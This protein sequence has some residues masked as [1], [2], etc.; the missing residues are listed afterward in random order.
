[1]FKSV[2]P[3]P[4]FINL[5][6]RILDFWRENEILEK[7]LHRND[8]PKGKELGFSE[9]DSLQ[10]KE[11]D[12]K[13]SSEKRFSFLDGPITAN[14]PMGVHHAWGRTLKDLFQRFRN[15]QGFK[16][17]FQNG[18]DNQGLWVEV[19]VEKKLGFK[20]K[21][22][23]EKFGI[24][25]FVEECKKY[26]LG[27]AKLM[28]KQS[29][30]LGYFMDWGNDYY[31]MSDENN[32]AI[33]HFLK[34]VWEDGNLYK[35]R[36]SVP[37]C[38]RCGTAISQHE[39]L[40]EEYQ[41]L[42]H[43]SVF[44]KYPMV[45]GPDRVQPSLRV[46]P[47]RGVSLLVW[48]TTPW[49]IPG[50][51]ALAVNPE[52]KYVGICRKPQTANR[53]SECLI[54][55]KSRLEVIGEPYEIVREFL[56]TELEGLKYIGPFDDLECVKEAREE[57]PETFHTVVLSKDLVSEEEGTGI[58]HI[59]TGCGTEDF[60]LG[61]EKNLPVIEVI[62]EA[63][64]YLDGFGEFSG[65]NA[66]DHPELILDYLGSGTPLACLKGRAPQGGAATK[67]LINPFLYKIEPFTH[68]YPVCWRCKTELVWRV[69][70]EW[71]IAMDD[72][73][74]KGAKSYRER[75]KKVIKDVRWIPEFGYARELDWLNNMEDWLISK[76]R[77]WGL[78]LPIWECECG[79]FEVISSYEELKE[80]A[81]FGWEE[82][83]DHT[84]HR[85]WVDAV[86][87]KCSK[88]GRLASRVLDVGNPW[89]DA[90]IVPFST[91]KYFKE[92]DFRESDSLQS[93]ESDSGASGNKTYWEKWFPADLVLECFPG[94]F[95]NWFYSLLAMSVVLEGTAP[96]KTLLGHA[97]VK[98]EKGEEMHKSKGNTIWFDEAAEKMGVDAMRWLYVRQNPILNLNFGYG[99]AEEIRRRFF[100]ILWN[101]YKFFVTYAELDLRSA[102]GLT[103]IEERINTDNL[104]VLDRWVL[105]KLNLLVKEV[106]EFLENY[107]N[108]KAAQAIESFVVKD[109]SAWYIRRIRDR[110][111]PSVPDGEDKLNAYRTLYY[112]LLN[113]TRLLAPF[114]PFLA[115]EIYQN[116]VSD[117]V[118][119]R[120]QPSLRVEPSWRRSVHLTNWP[121]WHDYLIDENVLEAMSL[122]REIC[123]KGHAARRAAGIKVRQPL[124]GI[125]VMAL[126]KFVAATHASPGIK[127]RH[128][129]QL[130]NL[131]KDELNV[132]EVEFAGGGELAVEL[133]TK[134]TPE[135]KL[136]GLAREIVRAIQNAR[137]EAGCNLDDRI[138]A[139]F[140]DTKENREAVEKFGDYI[141]RE[142]LSEGLQTGKRFEVNSSK[143]PNI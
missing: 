43:D 109:L 101:C 65:K 100:L 7:Y 63:A 70:E 40:T 32:Y 38:P 52:I 25:K 131:I 8:S 136:E 123:E 23:I 105:S 80:R 49:T 58:V 114:I 91:L 31:T 30:R 13:K 93:E 133:D 110:I 97:L 81:V 18:F 47:S 27:F 96:F 69:V 22:D 4:N 83:E 88:C 24:A 16:Q 55:A 90:G 57:N 85:P 45:G 89:L 117:R 134:I 44:L 21:R 26:T 120:V 39:I 116:L 51:V 35:G 34:K 19:E 36:D 92:S 56:G 20:S 130:R 2:E 15:M 9:S 125:K 3:K 14:N 42:T 37:W 122:V 86:K 98:D 107:K 11:S 59:A 132:K 53:K 6:H 71:Y 74:H 142:T 94:Q 140:P 29:Q 41:E 28:I 102:R 128:A 75:L 118:S 12:S 113:L 78:A 67:N 10:S 104:S 137:K 77:Y 46:E 76:K 129:V 111:G 87:I 126:E 33:W 141:R 66:K 139:T 112:I 61:L 127:A 54:L 135:L 82:F 84:P 48:T 17:R 138:I 1:M 60:R 5:E 79:R 108:H 143:H 68:R 73:R 106:T 72:T 50:N 99:P 95:K 62:D 119:D 121:I 115:E 124:A 64:S 103:R